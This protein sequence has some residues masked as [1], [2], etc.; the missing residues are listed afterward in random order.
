[1]PCQNLGPTIFIHTFL[2]NIVSWFIELLFFFFNCTA[3]GV[4]RSCF[5]FGLFFIFFLVLL[6]T[7]PKPLPMM[8]SSAN[9]RPFLRSFHHIPPQESFAKLVN[10]L[11]MNK[12]SADVRNVYLVKTRPKSPPVDIRTFARVKN[13]IWDQLLA[14]KAE[15]IQS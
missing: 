14:T 15:I 8:S 6:V 2:Y 1:M 7:I 10:E 12:I 5:T 13:L 3:I 11:F 4:H 9:Y